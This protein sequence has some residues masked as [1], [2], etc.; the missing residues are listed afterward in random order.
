M[1]ISVPWTPYAKVLVENSILS[2]E[3]TT[4]TRTLVLADHPNVIVSVNNDKLLTIKG[5]H[6]A[7][8]G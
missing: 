5:F 1:M 6:S 8:I 4:S 2:V 7:K 3:I